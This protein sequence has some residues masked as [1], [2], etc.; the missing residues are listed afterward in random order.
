MNGHLDEHV[1]KWKSRLDHVHRNLVSSQEELKEIEDAFGMH[2]DQREVLEMG[3]GENSYRK[4]QEGGWSWWWLVFL[5][6]V[7]AVGGLVWLGIIPSALF[8]Q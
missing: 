5:L 4:P 7:S 3:P 6:L 2:E 1:K 8:K